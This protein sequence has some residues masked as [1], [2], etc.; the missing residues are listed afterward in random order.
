ME[1]SSVPA[2]E[3]LLLFQEYCYADHTGGRA[4]STSNGILYKNIP[5]RLAKIPVSLPEHVVNLTYHRKV[6]KVM[7]L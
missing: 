4:G 5:E 2:Y 6:V 1:E 7:L 3:G